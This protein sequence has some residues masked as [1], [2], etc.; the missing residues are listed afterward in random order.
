[1]TPESKRSPRTEL[2]IKTDSSGLHTLKISWD[3]Y[4]ST[5]V[6]DLSDG[7]ACPE[8]Q[9]T[10]M[11]QIRLLWILS[12]LTEE[13]RIETTGYGSEMLRRTSLSLVHRPESFIRMLKAEEIS[14]LHSTN[15]LE[16]ENAVLS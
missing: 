13:L 11:Q 3:L 2:M 6:M 12:I 15:W 10:W 9:K 7:F 16:T 14:L 4:C 1:M 5:M 8:N